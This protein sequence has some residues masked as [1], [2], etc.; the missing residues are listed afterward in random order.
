MRFR[1]ILVIPM[2]VVSAIVATVY[3]PPIRDIYD[4]VV[5]RN[6]GPGYLADMVY[7]SRFDK[8]AR[9]VRAGGK[10]ERSPAEPNER[11]AANPS[12]PLVIACD[13]YYPDCALYLIKSGAKVTV[14]D[15]E[16]K[17]PL[18]A[19]VMRGNLRVVEELVNRGADVNARDG[20]GK[21]P[22]DT[23]L[24]SNNVQDNPEVVRLLLK[25]DG[26][27]TQCPEDYSDL[28]PYPLAD[29]KGTISILATRAMH[30]MPDVL[31]E[32]WIDEGANLRDPDSLFNNNLLAIATDMCSA[33]IVGLVLDHGYS[34][35]AKCN[36]NGNDCRPLHIAARRGQKDIIELLI[37]RGADVNA[38]DSD[39]RTPLDLLE[40]KRV[41]R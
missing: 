23:I 27:V 6:L 30:R 17:T 28:T 7:W 31:I 39:G 35:N 5:T 40:Q 34:P 26:R 37:A 10:L 21:T 8:V 1:A 41:I 20:R 22:L 24:K 25:K 33:R 9:Y 14:V 15:W 29:K 32:H 3:V 11:S 2:L 19:A 36:L 12:Q 16:K 4:K 13:Q 38:K 18:H